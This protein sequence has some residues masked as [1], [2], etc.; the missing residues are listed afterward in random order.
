MKKA[1][2]IVIYARLL[3]LCFAV[4]QYMVY[5]HQ[6]Y[7]HSSY[8]SINKSHTPVLKENCNVCDAM[9]HNYM[10]LTQHV[11]FVPVAAV[12]FHYQNSNPDLKFIQ[13]ILA[14]GRAPP[15]S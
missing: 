4:G 3:L 8:L 11:Y 5:A 10:V 7:K 2:L 15:V 14:S 1:K 6:H 9:H 13:L 12:L